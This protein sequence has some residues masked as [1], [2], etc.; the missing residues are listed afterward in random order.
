M[1]RLEGQHL[2]LLRQRR[3]QFRQPRAGAHRHHQLGRLVGDDAG[4]ARGVE[5]RARGGLP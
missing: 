1:R 5:Q 4:V 2:A 3:F